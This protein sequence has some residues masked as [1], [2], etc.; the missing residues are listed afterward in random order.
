MA[1]TTSS[2]V[3]DDLDSVGP[4]S[5][6]VKL[7]RYCWLIRMLYWPA[8]SPRRASSCRRAM[9]SDDAWKGM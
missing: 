1:D 7:T 3:S 6:Q 9:K 5:V 4:A 2:V 8:R